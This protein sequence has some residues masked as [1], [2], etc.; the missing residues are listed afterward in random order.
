MY[1]TLVVLHLISVGI[2]VGIVT[3]SIIGRL[4]GKAIRGTTAELIMYRSMAM[5]GEIMGKLAIGG[6]LITGVAMSWMNYSFFP[7]NTI[8]WLFL[9]QC[10]F[11]VLLIVAFTGTIPRGE[12]IKHMATAEL[13]GPGAAQGASEGLRELVAKQYI[14][15]LLIG[16]LVLTNMIL[17]ESKA[18]M[19][20]TGQ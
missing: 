5:N 1:T 7:V 11:I 9:K 19:W 12:K 15:V 14:T 2:G 10:V 20:V 17:G 6:L 18:M 8:P 4:K 16:A 3:L 13:Q